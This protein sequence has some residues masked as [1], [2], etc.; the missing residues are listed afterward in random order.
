EK[1]L[2]E[3][4]TTLAQYDRRR[5]LTRIGT[6]IGLGLL[7]AGGGLALYET[8]QTP[9]QVDYNAK[10][11]E[12]VA[13]LPETRI[14]DLLLER[15]MP[16]FEEPGVHTITRGNFSYELGR[17]TVTEVGGAPHEIFGKSTSDNDPDPSTIVTP[18]ESGRM[19]VPYVDGFNTP[20]EI[21]T[22]TGG[23]GGRLAFGITYSPE[24]PFS[25]AFDSFISISRPPSQI[26]PDAEREATAN[27]LRQIY[28]KE[29]CTFLMVD[30][31]AEQTFNIMEQAGRPSTIT[32]VDGTGKRR[33]VSMIYETILALEQ[34]QGRTQQI[35][36]GGGFVLSSQA[37]GSADYFNDIVQNS[38]N[39]DLISKMGVL[40]IAPDNSSLLENTIAFSLANANQFK[41]FAVQGDATRYP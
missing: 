9:E 39:P 18:I 25:S 23:K 13:E 17:G 11:A 14:K 31:L 20:E 33:E 27:A 21:A 36:D 35:I 40:P 29:A 37:A 15:V 12:Y 2:S 41:E 3:E 32:V 34:K 38:L 24:S 4:L 26:V 28:I 8:Q 30:L 1:R 16:R 19:L 6:G 7:A 10:L 5:F 22:A